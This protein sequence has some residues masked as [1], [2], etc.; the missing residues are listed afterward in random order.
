MT[1]MEK[2]TGMIA[3]ASTITLATLLMSP[4]AFADTAQNGTLADA[5]GTQRMGMMRDH[6]GA[7]RGPGIG[8]IVRSVSGTSFTL[9]SRGFGS[10]ATTTYS[11]DASGA[12]ITKDGADA[13]IAALVAGVHA[14]VEG[15]VSGTSIQATEIHVGLPPRDGMGPRGGD[16]NS[17]STTRAHMMDEF[18]QIEGSGE[19]IIGGTVSSVSGNTIVITNKGGVSYSIDTSG[20]TITKAGDTVA[21]TQVAIGDSVL[22]QGAINGTTVIASSVIDQGTPPAAQAT[23]DSGTATQKGP[24]GF[25]GRIGGFFRHLFGF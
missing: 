3:A 21:L 10:S 15:T 1:S 7:G 20:A 22:A 13:T 14:I 16:W 5:N 17:G 25:F 4:V 23:T 11:V 8:G 12:T 18:S 9:E 19:P 2:K 24:M 6:M